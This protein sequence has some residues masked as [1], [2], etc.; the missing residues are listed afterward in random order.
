MRAHTPPTWLKGS[1]APCDIQ[2]RLR[3][4]KTKSTPALPRETCP[5]RVE[6]FREVRCRLAPGNSP[7]KA[8]KPEDKDK[9]EE[10]IREARRRLS[11]FSPPP[12][13]TRKGP[14]QA[15]ERLRK[16]RSESLLP[17][18]EEAKDAEQ[19][20]DD[21][22]RQ[23]E[24]HRVDDMEAPRDKGKQK[25][26]AS[27]P[28]HPIELHHP[29]SEMAHDHQCDWKEKYVTLQ[30]EVD[31]QGQTDDIGLEG[32]TIVLHMKGRDDLVINTDLR[33]LE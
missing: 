13:E 23:A 4:I 11:H 28:T 24:R 21:A 32:L 29:V 17:V 7:P 19:S 33:N 22:P 6:D 16:I 25:E 10:E 5:E 3:T 31:A 26:A 8:P 2:E 15:E 9:A 12:K 30:S 18:H 27:V 20:Q 1:S 14:S